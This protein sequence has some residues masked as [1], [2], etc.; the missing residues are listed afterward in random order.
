MFDTLGAPFPLNLKAYPNEPR[1]RTPGG[2]PGPLGLPWDPSDKS[3]HKTILQ[4]TTNHRRA[5]PHHHGTT[6]PQNHQYPGPPGL[7]GI[8][9]T[10]K[11]NQPGRGHLG[12]LGF[13]GTRVVSPT[14]SD[15]HQHA[16]NHDQPGRKSPHLGPPFPE[17]E[18]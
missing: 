17:P 11:V 14:P 15:P 4:T 12:P 16:H 3:Y 9:S 1:T 18:R 2:P 6:K 7:A 8:T 5:E 10:L 13:P